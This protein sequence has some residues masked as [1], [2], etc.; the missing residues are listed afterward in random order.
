MEKH[1]SP[2]ENNEFDVL[3]AGSLINPEVSAP[4]KP[5]TLKICKKN[6]ILFFLLKSPPLARR[7]LA[8]SVPIRSGFRKPVFF[9]NVWKTIPFQRNNNEFE[10]LRAGSLIN[11]KVPTLRKPKKQLKIRKHNITFW[12]KSPPIARRVLAS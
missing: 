6:K 12:L 11:P 1:D 4:G 7:V 3:K 10:V 8:I 2:N 9:E 5:E